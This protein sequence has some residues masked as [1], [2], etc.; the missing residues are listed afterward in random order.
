MSAKTKTT[1]AGEGVVKL[2]A[3]FDNFITMYQTLSCNLIKKMNTRTLCFCPLSCLK[4]RSGLRNSTDKAAR[5][6][7]TL[8]NVYVDLV[9]FTP[10][11]G[12]S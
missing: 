6:S 10:I 9:V 8:V 4:I 1:G 5:T 11:A 12:T 7:I 3:D 2:S